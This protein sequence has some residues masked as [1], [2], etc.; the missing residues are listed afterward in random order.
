MVSS[1]LRI[2]PACW[3]YSMI[4]S[5]SCAGVMGTVDNLIPPC[6]ARQ[7]GRT[8]IILLACIFRFLAAWSG[9]GAPTMPPRWHGT[10]TTAGSGPTCATGSRRPTRSRT[11][12][13]GSAIAC[14]PCRRPT[15]PS[16]SHG[17]AVGG[18]GLVLRTDVERVDAEVGYWLG[19]AHW[20]QRRDVGGG[21]GVRAVG[22]GAVQPRA[23]PRARLRVQRRIRARAGEGGIR[24]GG[25][26]AAQRLQGRH[27]DRPAALRAGARGVAA[28]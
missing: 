26:P 7:I 8:S 4:G 23:A 21:A 6:A 15:L 20:G 18:I 16:K 9:P 14:A 24:P 5:W 2:R 13:H 17:E 1:G 19:E 3:T 11:P 12:M 27:A 22:A 10:P 25:A 28:V